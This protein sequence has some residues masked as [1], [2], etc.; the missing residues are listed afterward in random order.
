MQRKI[1]TSCSDHNPQRNAASGKSSMKE[2]T[3][4]KYFQIPK[5]TNPLKN[6]FLCFAIF[7][8]ALESEVSVQPS[9]R[10]EGKQTN[11][12]RHKQMDIATNRLNLHRKGG[13]P[14]WS[15]WLLRV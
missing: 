7:V 3:H 2:H 8:S 13:G 6:K 1:V 5:I 9:F 4:F 15:K 10:I 11:H 12:H 14:S